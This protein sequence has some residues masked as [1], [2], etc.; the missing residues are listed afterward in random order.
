[1]GRWCEFEKLSFIIPDRHTLSGLFVKILS[2]HVS[3]QCGLWWVYRDTK[4]LKEILDTIPRL[5][6][7]FL[8]LYNLKIKIISAIAALMGP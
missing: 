3:L 1:M 6:F 8:I 7:C 4:A 5:M 2:I